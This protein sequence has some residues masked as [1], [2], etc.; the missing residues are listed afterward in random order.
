M[1]Q[2]ADLA[3]SGVE[4]E[5]VLTNGLQTDASYDGAAGKVALEFHYKSGTDA[6]NNKIAIYVLEKIKEY[7]I[8]YGLADR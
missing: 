2:D 3:L 6:T 8:N 1:M 4:F 5:R 7:A